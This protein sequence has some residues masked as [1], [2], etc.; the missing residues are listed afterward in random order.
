MEANVCLAYV[1]VPGGGEVAGEG[2]SRFPKVCYVR[3]QPSKTLCEFHTQRMLSN[4]KGCLSFEGTF[5]QF[6]I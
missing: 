3:Y 5:P 4:L 2:L 1:S 6:Q